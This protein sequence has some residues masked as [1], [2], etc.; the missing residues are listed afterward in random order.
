MDGRQFIEAEADV[1]DDEEMNPHQKEDQ[2]Y[3]P[4]ELAR[5]TN[6]DFNL[7]K[8]EAKYREKALREE[9]GIEEESEGSYLDESDED[10]DDEIKRQGLLPGIND[11]KM[12]Q[13]RVKKNFERTAV[14]ALLNKSMYY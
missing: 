3:K 11:P 12:W 9:A 10:D 5:K 1:S 8:L 2:Y 6:K 7:N 4:E 14:I 13:V